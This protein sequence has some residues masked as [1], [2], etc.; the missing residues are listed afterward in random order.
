MKL[1]AFI[2]TTLLGTGIV[3]S[4]TCPSDI[5]YE[6]HPFGL[7][8]SD[9]FQAECELIA[10]KTVVLLTD[11]ISDISIIPGSPT[12]VT[13]YIDAMLLLSVEGAPIQLA[14]TTDVIITADANAPFGYWYSTGSV[15]NMDAGIGCIGFTGSSADWG[16]AALGGSNNDGIYP[17]ELV[18][19]ARIAATSPDLSS[20]IPNGSWLR[21]L[22]ASF[23]LQPVVLQDTLHATG[24]QDTIP[25]V[26]TG[27][28]EIVPGNQYTY[29]V[30]SY[31]GLTYDWEVEFGTILFGQGSNAV[32]VIWDNPGNGRLRVFYPLNSC[33]TEG[34]ITVNATSTGMSELENAGVKIKALSEGSYS[35][36][37]KSAFNVMVTDL[38]G[39]PVLQQKHFGNTE[40][41]LDLGA[42]ASGVYI[43]TF[44]N[45]QT[46]LSLK[47]VPQL[48]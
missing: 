17:L 30:P 39:Q 26:I 38:L 4:Q 16:L 6:Y 24:Y 40:T 10:P 45:N 44:Q 1:F 34:S 20:I 3:H 9:P 14:V 41:I 11:T 42:H 36:K 13:F 2:L 8:P 43:V 37:T 25:E 33:V 19:D 12:A 27:Q 18:V 31:P 48:F 47:L 22:P 28:T 32:V 35:I 46:S 7:Y 21:H 29:S 15:P 5:S 23:G